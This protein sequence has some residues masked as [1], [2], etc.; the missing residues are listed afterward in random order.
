[1]NATEA[2]IQAGYSKKTAKALGS[3]LL[4]RVDVQEAIAKHTQKALTKHELTA[5]RVLEELRRVAF[6]DIRGF[7][8]AAGNIKPISDLSEEQGAQ[9]AGVEVILK[10]AR[11]GDGKIDE[12]HKIRLHPKLHALELLAKH[13]ALLTEV[14]ELRIS[15]RLT[16]DQVQHLSDDELAAKLRDALA[17][18]APAQVVGASA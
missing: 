1:M 5:D 8:D 14:S 18:I 2:A 7:Y 6:A 4:T 10:N 3:R 13:F 17:S 16:I 15:G 12:V 11:A 9:L